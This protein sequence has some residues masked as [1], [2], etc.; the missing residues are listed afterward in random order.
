M[1]KKISLGSA[2]AYMAIVAAVAVSLTMIYSRN[3]FNQKLRDLSEREAMYSAVFELDQYVRSNYYKD[4]DDDQ[5]NSSTMAGYI[6]GLGDPYARL[7]T[8][9]EYEV[10]QSEDGKYTG[11]G[12]V[13]ELAADG[14]IRVA[15]VYPDSPAEAAGIAAGDLI[16]SV[17]GVQVNSSDASY[18][19]LAASFRGDAGTKITLVRRRGTEDITLELTRR[20]VEVPTIRSS[21]LSDGSGYI[22]IT[23]IGSSTGAQFEKAVK[24]MESDGVS[25]LIFDVRGLE[26]DSMKTV[27]DM[28]DILLPRITTVYITRADGVMETL[29]TSDESSVPLP[30]VVLADE[31]TK[32]ASEMFAYALR[33]CGAA[34][35]V[36]IKTFGKGT[37]QEVKK[38]R[39]GSAVMLTTAYYS[40]PAGGTYDLTGVTPDYEVELGVEA[41]NRN[42]VLGDPELDVQLKKAQE[43]ALSLARAASNA[44]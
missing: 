2:I 19:E 43:V 7:M 4:V 32:G 38:L 28:L 9:R 23:G 13:S 37:L 30:M 42:N 25:A 18:E 15:E 27:S 10:Y 39:D 1:N 22:R 5:L 33:D 26:T 3:L 31:S 8:A 29:Y 34:R 16:T 14:Y 41:A 11:I 40:G 24:Q 20:Q 35:V 12:I 17:D 6:A 44:S 21:T 36:G